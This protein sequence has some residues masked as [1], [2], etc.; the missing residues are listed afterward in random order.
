MDNTQ[1]NRPLTHEEAI[2]F[3]EAWKLMFASKVGFKHLVTDLERLQ[4]YIDDLAA[5]NE[6]LKGDPDDAS[7][8]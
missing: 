6:Q 8:Q 5:E 2:A 7:E 4:E 3:V 1:E